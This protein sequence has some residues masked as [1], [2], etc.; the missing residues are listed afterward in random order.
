[1]DSRWGFFFCF[2]GFFSWFPSIKATNKT[3]RPVALMKRSIG[4]KG[5][6]GTGEWQL[7]PHGSSQ[8]YCV[9][10]RKGATWKGRTLWLE[11]LKGTCSKHHAVEGRGTCIWHLDMWLHCTIHT[12]VCEQIRSFKT[13]ETGFT[14]NSRG[15]TSIIIKVTIFIQQTFLIHRGLG[16]K[17]VIGLKCIPTP[18]IHMLNLSTTTLTLHI[19]SEWDCI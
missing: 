6:K 17:W 1:M 18:E 2:F 11:W 13:Q 3:Q 9:Q 16:I 10:D 7:E 15:L 12:L 19:T 8:I 14:K 5:E 4:W